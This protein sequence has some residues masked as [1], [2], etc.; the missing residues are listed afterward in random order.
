MTNDPPLPEPSR[1]TGGSTPAEDQPDAFD[2]GEEYGIP[3][4]PP[5]IFRTPEPLFRVAGNRAVSLRLDV[6]ISNIPRLCTLEITSCD[7]RLSA[8]EERYYTGLAAIRG[9]RERTSLR[10]PD[11]TRIILH[12]RADVAL[13]DYSIGALGGAMFS[14]GAVRAIL[15]SDEARVPF[16]NSPPSDWLPLRTVVEQAS[17]MGVG[18][19]LGG[20][21]VPMM[22]GVYA[23]GLFMVKFITPIVAAAGDATAAGVSAKIRSAFGL[24]P[25]PATAEPNVTSDDAASPS[26]PA[27]PDEPQSPPPPSP[28]D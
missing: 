28:R 22:V 23:G 27:S 24:Q 20:S 1:S 5:D 13:L 16:F 21:S 3:L 25:E 18:I 10:F 7:Y 26:A 14:S 2:G 9:N 12:Y 19:T 8:E 6:E 11:G 15:N 17:A 4:G